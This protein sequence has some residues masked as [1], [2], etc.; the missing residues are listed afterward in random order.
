[1]ASRNKKHVHKY[2]KVHNP[3][4]GFLWFCGFG[5]CQHHMPKHYELG[6]PGK[7]TI[8]WKCEGTTT[9]DSRTMAM[10]KPLCADCDPNAISEDISA[11][12]EEQIQTLKDMGVLD[13]LD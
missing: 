9:L 10:D 5:D 11:L 6:L 1:M 12:T 4:G 7:S 3:S 8:C 2:Y 13:K